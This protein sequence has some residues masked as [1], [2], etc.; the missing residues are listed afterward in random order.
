MEAFFIS[1]EEIITVQLV[2]AENQSHKRDKAP[3]SIAASTG[4]QNLLL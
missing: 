2:S 4:L 3:Q 1:L